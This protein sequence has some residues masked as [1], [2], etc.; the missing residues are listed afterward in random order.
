MNEAQ[1]AKKLTL[2][3]GQLAKAGG[4]LAA[5]WAKVGRAQ[6]A[7]NRI[8]GELASLRLYPTTDGPPIQANAWLDASGHNGSR[9]SDTPEPEIT[10]RTLE[11]VT[12]PGE[13][14]AQRD[15]F[16]AELD[17]SLRSVSQLAADNAARRSD[18]WASK[19]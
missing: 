4:Q 3:E 5:A 14:D 2:K 13:L 1:K 17:A 9:E 6:D 12:T 10:E 18:A 19:A 16:G 7:V 8:M 15:A 11:P